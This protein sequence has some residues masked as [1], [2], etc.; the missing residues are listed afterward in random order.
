MITMVTIITCGMPRINIGMVTNGQST[1][2]E[3]QASQ[4]KTIPVHQTTPRAVAILTIVITTRVAVQVASMLLRVVL[5]SPTQTRCLG[6]ACMAILVGTD[7]NY[8]L[9]W[10]IYIKA[11]CG[12]RRSLFYSQSIITTPR[13]LPTVQPTCVQHGSTTATPAVVLTTPVSLLQ[14]MQTNISTCPT[15]V[16]TTLSCTTLA[17]SASIGRQVLP[18]GPATV[19]T[20]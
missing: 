8:G 19:R 6:T 15:W 7:L 14:S 10:V 11:A 3:I 17:R 16:T 20:A 18:Q 5:L 2:Q 13:N 4:H 1:C 9:Q 12:L